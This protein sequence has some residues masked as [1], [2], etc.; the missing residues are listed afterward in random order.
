MVPDWGGM[1]R[2]ERPCCCGMRRGSVEGKG[3]VTSTRLGGRP[4][5][6]SQLTSSWLQTGGDARGRLFVSG[7]VTDHEVVFL[8]VLTMCEAVC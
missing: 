5:K 2:P 4:G 8:E 7:C 6:V 1:G 3:F